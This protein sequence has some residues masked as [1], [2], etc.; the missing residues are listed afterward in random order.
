MF[1]IR[2]KFHSEEESVSKAYTSSTQYAPIGRVAVSVHREDIDKAVVA[3]LH[4]NTIE[5]AKAIGYQEVFFAD[6][7]DEE[8]S[9]SKAYTSSTQYAPIGRVAV[10]TARAVYWWSMF[11]SP[12][13]RTQMMKFLGLAVRRHVMQR[14]VL[15]YMR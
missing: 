13:Q 15:G 9:V 2:S 11:K 4:Q 14:Q 12:W 6:F 10:N 3:E 8:E 7:P 5:S 1:Y